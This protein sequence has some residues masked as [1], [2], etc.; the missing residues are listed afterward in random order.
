[1]LAAGGKLLTLV[2]LSEVHMSVFLP[3]ERAGQLKVGADAR[4]VMDAWPDRA[5]AARVSF[6]SDEAQFTPR[7]VETRSERARKLMFRVKVSVD[8]AWLEANA[9]RVKPGMAGM[10]WLRLDSAVPWPT[11]L[12]R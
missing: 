9:A 5:I 10:A 12:P 11:T 7:E 3:S 6:V 2:N 8:P 1:M 4:I